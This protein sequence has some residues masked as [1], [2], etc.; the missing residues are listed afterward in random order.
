VVERK[1]V[2]NHVGSFFRLT[3]LSQQPES[4]KAAGESPAKFGMQPERDAALGEELSS[5]IP[6]LVCKGAKQWR[7]H[8]GSII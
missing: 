5:C 8:P 4:K 3:R 6:I 7:L 1:T 2:F